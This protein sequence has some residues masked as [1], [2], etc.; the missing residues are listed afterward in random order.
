MTD[1]E[2]IFLKPEKKCA[3]CDYWEFG[4]RICCS[5]GFFPGAQA[6]SSAYK[7]GGECHAMGGNDGKDCPTWV[8]RDTATSPS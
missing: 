6:I 5:W 8:A 4:Q 2:M 7:A 3:T 1:M